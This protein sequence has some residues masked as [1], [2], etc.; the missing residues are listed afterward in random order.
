VHVRSYAATWYSPIKLFTS[1]ERTVDSS[2][3]LRATA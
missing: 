2:A 3:G 1:F